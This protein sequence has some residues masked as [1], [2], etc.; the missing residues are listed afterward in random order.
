MDEEKGYG[1]IN[2]VKV[3]KAENHISRASWGCN[4]NSNNYNNLSCAP[5]D[6][7]NIL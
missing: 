6:Q 4:I 2:I 7:Y 3:E 1:G 5:R